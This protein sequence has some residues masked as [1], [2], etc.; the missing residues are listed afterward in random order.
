MNTSSILLLGD[1]KK[2]EYNA[3]SKR[4][5][6]V[7]VVLFPFSQLP[8]GR[9]FGFIMFCNLWTRDHDSIP[10]HSARGRA[11]WSAMSWRLN[12]DTPL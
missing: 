3:R 5:M 6:L 4:I 12:I 8:V 11:W 1:T 2:L 7:I 10:S 9:I